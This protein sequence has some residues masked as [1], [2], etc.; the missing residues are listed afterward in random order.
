MQAFK[1]V[2]TISEWGDN[3]GIGLLALVV[4]NILRKF[5]GN[6]VKSNTELM[7]TKFMQNL[8]ISFLGV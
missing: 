7:G 5:S 6:R 3:L 2:Q 8:W 4:V 1:F